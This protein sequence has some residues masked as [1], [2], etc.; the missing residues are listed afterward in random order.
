MHGPSLLLGRQI[1]TGLLVVAVAVSAAHGEDSAPAEVVRSAPERADMELCQAVVAA[2]VTLAE[3]VA[4]VSR[5]PEHALAAEFSRGA[6]GHLV[7]TVWT[8]KGRTLDAEFFAYTGALTTSGWDLAKKP[9]GVSQGLVKVARWATFMEER[10]NKLEEVLDRTLKA[11]HHDKREAVA[12]ISVEP[13]LEGFETRVV[14]DGLPWGVEHNKSGRIVRM[15]R[16]PYLEEREEA[17]RRWVGR[18]LPELDVEKAEWLNT[19]EP[20]RLSALTGRVVL[21]LVTDPG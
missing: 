21:L 6:D 20:P 15:K 17:A 18:Q 12:A 19:K 4:R 10:E 16:P 2:P 5:T 8:Q 7:L 13:A 9:V 11:R 3:A 1:M 14:V